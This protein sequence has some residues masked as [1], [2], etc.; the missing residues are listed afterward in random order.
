MI[1]ASVFP[2][3][4]IYDLVVADDGRQRAFV[5]LAAL[6]ISFFL[7]RT[8]ARM[9]RAFSWWPGGVETEDGVHLHHFVWG[10]FLMLGAGFVG[11]GVHLHQPWSGIVAPLFGVGAGLTLDEFAL[12]TRLEDVYW[13]PAG[14]SS[15]EAVAVVA[16]VGLLVVIG[17]RP[18]ELETAA[19]AVTVTLAIG[20]SL[21]VAVVAFLKGRIWPGAVGLFILPVG[22]FAALRLAH[23]TS[24]WARHFYPAG[25]RRM[26]RAGQRF[27]NPARAGARVRTSLADLIGGRPTDAQHGVEESPTQ[28]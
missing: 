19:S 10:I 21:A 7:I 9:T 17:V 24:P 28:R 1:N 20:L 11:I 3:E 12:W 25:G 8:S 6:L 22:L 18:F 13:S 16:S 27:E 14:R 4:H 15:L 2:V 23:P 5:C 26:A